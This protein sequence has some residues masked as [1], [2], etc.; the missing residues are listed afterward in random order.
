MNGQPEIIDGELRKIILVN[1]KA[2]EIIFIEVFAN[3]CLSLAILT[4]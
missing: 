1:F 4:D 3:G 2:I